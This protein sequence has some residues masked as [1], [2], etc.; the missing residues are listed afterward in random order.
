[1]LA[2]GNEMA[3]SLHEVEVA[4]PAVAKYEKGVSE[5]FKAK[6]AV[7]ANRPKD[8]AKGSTPCPYCKKWLPPYHQ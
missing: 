5:A 6:Q 2:E 1:M 4:K 8:A 3:N 7:T